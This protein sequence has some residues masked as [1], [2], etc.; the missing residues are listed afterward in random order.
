M[1][2][3]GKNMAILKDKKNKIVV[4]PEEKGNITTR[5]PYDLWSDMDRMFDSFRSD[6]DDLF[7]PWGQGG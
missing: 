2:K 1:L 6:F 7:W 5:G 4:R 3:G